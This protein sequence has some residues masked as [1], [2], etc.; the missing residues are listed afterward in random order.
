[1]YPQHTDGFKASNNRAA[2]CQM[3]RQLRQGS[4]FEDDNARYSELIFGVED[5]SYV[6]QG[7]NFCDGLVMNVLVYVKLENPSALGETM[8][9]AVKYV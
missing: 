6:D 9:L 2:L 3:L 4:D 7:T 5:M 1:V 8:D